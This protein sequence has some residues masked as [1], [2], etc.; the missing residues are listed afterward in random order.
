[1]ECCIC[2]RKPT[3]IFTNGCFQ[4]SLFIWKMLN[5]IPTVNCDM[6]S[7]ETGYDRFDELV[8][9]K[10][11]RLTTESVKKYQI[12][13]T[14]SLTLNPSNDIEI[15]KAIK[16]NGIKLVDVL[17]GNLYILLQE[18]FVFDIHNIM[19]NYRNPYIDQVWVLEMY[20]YAKDFLEM[21][22]DRPVKVMRYVWDVDIIE[23][24]ISINDINIPSKMNNGK[25]NICIYE[26]NMSL[27]KNG[28]IPLLIAENYF[29]KFPDRVNKVY[30]FCKETMN[31]NGFYE[32]LELCKHG[33]FEYHGRMIM[34]TTIDNIQK[35]SGYK[36]VVLS[37]TLL[38]N[39]NFL[40]L[41]L[42]YMRIQIVHNCSP[43]KNG[44]YYDS[45]K[46]WDAVD[47]I[48]KARI[49]EPDEQLTTQ[50]IQK[51]SCDNVHIQNDWSFHMNRIMAN[52]L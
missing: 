18:E 25:I 17:C 38:N 7:V 29:R 4:Q 35:S 51:F 32:N 33:K 14:L 40:H 10:V 42:F 3:N 1:M 15:L 2:V 24:Y 21:V 8:D 13:F 39:L 44:L 19:R 31:N 30:M 12:V 41:E 34:P 37:N 20:A 11:V 52:T 45:L 43:F 46:L 28:F 49:E 16:A 9:V 27:H 5:M 22:Y 23:K 6:V 50:I 47:L 36:T 26:A 48:E